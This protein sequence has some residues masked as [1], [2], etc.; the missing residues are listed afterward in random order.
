MGHMA[1]TEPQCLYRCALYLYFLPSFIHLYC[2]P[3]VTEGLTH[4][5]K[6]VRLEKNVFPHLLCT[7]PCCLPHV[8]SQA[9]LKIFVLVMVG[10]YRLMW[11]NSLKLL[12]E[13]LQPCNSCHSFSDFFY[14]W[15]YSECQSLFVKQCY[16]AAGALDVHVTATFSNWDVPCSGIC[17]VWI[18]C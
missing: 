14:Y 5:C 6:L 17:C 11:R 2:S 7:P 18:L 1:C 3:I 4:L 16:V 9:S 15:L 12:E 10:W 13:S 8:C